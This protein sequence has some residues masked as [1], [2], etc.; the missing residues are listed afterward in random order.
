MFEVFGPLQSVAHN[1]YDTLTSPQEWVKGLL[2][3]LCEVV[4]AAGQAVW[5]FGGRLF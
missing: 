3:L 2:G 4:A 1:M 5:Q